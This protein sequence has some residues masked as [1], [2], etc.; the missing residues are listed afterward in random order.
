MIR[1]ICGPKGYGK[2]KIIIDE[3]NQDVKKA[4][5]HVVFITDTKRY[6]FDLVHDIRFIDINDYSVT[7]EDALRGFIK[8]IVAC[9]SDTQY[10]FIDGIARMVGKPLSETAAFFY[11]IEKLADQYNLTVV[12]TVSC[13][14]SELPDFI[15]KYL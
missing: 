4:D 12:F 11:M 9:N 7:G 13:E 3:A 8:G 14:R 2:T 6:M 15:A 5:G 1:V 10:I